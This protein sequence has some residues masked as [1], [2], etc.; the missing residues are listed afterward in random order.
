MPNLTNL[1]LITALLLADWHSQ[2]GIT[3]ASGGP[4][5]SS[6]LLRIYNEI[7]GQNGDDL[8]VL[9]SERQLMRSILFL[10][11]ADLQSIGDDARDKVDFWFDKVFS[12]NPTDSKDDCNSNYLQKV[13]EVYE[14]HNSVK[15]PN[16]EQLYITSRKNI[17]EFCEGQFAELL[18]DLASRVPKDKLISLLDKYT[19]IKLNQ[20]V[21]LSESLSEPVLQLLNIGKKTPGVEVENAWKSGPCQEILS[22]LDRPDMTWYLDFINMCKYDSSDQR[23]HCSEPLKKWIA[24]VDMCQNI[25]GLMPRIAEIIDDKRANPWREKFYMIFNSNASTPSMSVDKLLLTLMFLYSNSEDSPSIADY[26][27]GLVKFWFNSLVNFGE[28]DCT[29]KH[30]QKMNAMYQPYVNNPNAHLLHATSRRNLIEYCCNLMSDLPT[31]LVAQVDVTK[32]HVAFLR[33]ESTST[34]ASQYITDELIAE[35][36]TRSLVRNVEAADRPNKG[37]VMMHSWNRGRC[38][39]II[40]TLERPEM[41]QYMDF[42]QMSL[43]DQRN[44]LKF[45]SMPIELWV[46]VIDICMTIDN[47]IPVYV[48]DPALVP[49]LRQAII[50]RVRKEVRRTET[51]VTMGKSQ[52]NKNK[53]VRFN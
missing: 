30:V 24:V 29:V 37:K 28:E 50:E 43:L 32:S 46:R 44:Y 19:A 16:L 8:M 48:K 31:K 25:D 5:A 17:I 9:L 53:K 41:K 35:A 47:W 18:T 14:R 6:S 4:E 33:P 23:W 7:F 13:S 3:A 12:L 51:E 22:F 45:C 52:M 10:H 2:S 21:D 27:K 26:N 20:S 39:I 1:L 15:N 38:R 34:Q 49:N 42:V 11:E 36:L 40:K